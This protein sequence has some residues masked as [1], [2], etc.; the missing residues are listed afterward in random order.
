METLKPILDLISA[1]ANILTIAASSIAICVFILKRKELSSAL[2]L[3]LNWSYQTTL[4]D[5]TGK[6]DRL[7]EYNATEPT[8]LPEIKNILHEIAGQMRGNP[9][10]LLAAPVLPDRIES[11]AGGRKL[12]EP[13][14]RTMVAEVREVIRNLQLRNI[15]QD[16]DI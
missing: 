14:K 10:L 5:I 4:S 3:L 15:K 1:L 7:N 8:D 12:T 11:L 6:L 13:N 9:H 16:I 2:A